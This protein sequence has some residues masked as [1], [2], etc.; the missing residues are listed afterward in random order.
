MRNKEEEV[1]KEK[2]AHLPADVQSK[3][4]LRR[5]QV[6]ELKVAKKTIAELKR[7]KSAV[8]SKSIRTNR[9][10]KKRYAR[11]IKTI[12]VDLK[13]KHIAEWK[14]VTGGDMD[15]EMLEQIQQEE[16][17]L[18]EGDPDLTNVDMID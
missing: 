3:R 18:L 10:L 1:E 11:E 6:E 14:L 13:R 9:E 16:K 12:L 15:E 17:R 7:R 8:G 4:Q 2:E 5:K